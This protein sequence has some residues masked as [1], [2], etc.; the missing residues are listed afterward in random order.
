MYIS[1]NGAPSRLSASVSPHYDRSLKSTG[2]CR[3]SSLS[4]VF[5]L[6]AKSWWWKV[7]FDIPN[8]DVLDATKVRVLELVQYSDVVELYVQVLVNRFEG[9]PDRNVVFELNCHG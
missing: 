8:K 1:H 2:L 3:S 4:K 6:G 9:A 5:P 7:G